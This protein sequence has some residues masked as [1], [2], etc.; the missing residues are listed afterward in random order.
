MDPQSPSAGEV[1]LVPF[2]PE[3]HA[4]YLYEWFYDPRY[5]DCF[6]NGVQVLKL[7]DFQEIE[8][9]ANAAYMM[10][11]EPKAGGHFVIGYV[12]C[13]MRTPTT[14]VVAIMVTEEH[15]KR[16]KALAAMQAGVAFLKARGVHKVVCYVR[17]ENERLVGIMEKLGFVKGQLETE[18]RYENDRWISEQ[19]MILL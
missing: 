18:E 4:L 10:I 19:E 6:R 7:K 11:V 16:G 15:Q 5:R 3:E 12:S 1:R 14:A 17:P 2:E 9:R 13:F 8:R